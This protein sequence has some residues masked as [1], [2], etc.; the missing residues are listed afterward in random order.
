MS[1]RAQAIKKAEKGRFLSLGYGLVAY[2]DTLSSFIKIFTLYSVLSIA[3]LL[4]ISLMFVSSK[5]NLTFTARHSIG[6]FGQSEPLCVQVDMGVQNVNIKCNSGLISK[7]HSFGIIA[8]DE[9]DLKN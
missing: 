5:K 3:S 2:F 8:K 4:L 1:Y 6:I 7:F 9:I